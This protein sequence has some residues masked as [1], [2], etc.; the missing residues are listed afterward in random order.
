MSIKNRE[1]SRREFLKVAGATG[2]AVVISWSE[3][4]KAR[5]AERGGPIAIRQDW[6]QGGHQAAFFV[7]LD[8][9]W[10]AEKSLSVQIV[11]GF[12]SA[13]TAKLIGIGKEQMGQCDA[14]AIILTL[15]KGTKQLMVGSYIPTAPYCIVSPKGKGIKTPKDLEGKTLAANAATGEYTF[16][17]AFAKKTGINV[18]SMTINTVSP[19]MLNIQL[20]TGKVDGVMTYAI[21]G[22]A[23]A[24][25]NNLDINVIMYKNYGVDV[26]S[27]SLTAY[28]PWLEERG[29]DELLRRFLDASYRGQK[30]AMLNP[31][32]AIAAVKKHAPD[33]IIGEKEER[34]QLERLRI[35][36]AGNITEENKT[37]GLGYISEDKMR[38]TNDVVTEYMHK[39]PEP[40]LALDKIYTNKYLPDPMIKLSPAEWQKVSDLYED[41]VKLLGI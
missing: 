5:G 10:Y 11:R 37:M 40:K 39:G 32:E 18:N 27:N 14:G 12:G 41:Y 8:K 34:F 28:T 35:W 1:I 24:K 6:I 9:G 38:A 7:A 30:Y 20:L 33:A 2:A 13:D 4:G 17:P 22:V 15:L 3:G 29:N 21:S 25:V 36:A 26:Y 23:L 19:D 16:W 31:K